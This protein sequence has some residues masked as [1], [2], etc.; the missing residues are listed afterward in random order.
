[1]KT[2]ETLKIEAI[3]HEQRDRTSISGKISE[4]I[5]YETARNL[6]TL[7]LCGSPRAR[8]RVRARLN[9]RSLNDV[10]DQSPQRYAASFGFDAR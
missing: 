4:A 1:M 7:V 8:A 6:T 2:Q 3:L 9:R 5:F 10:P